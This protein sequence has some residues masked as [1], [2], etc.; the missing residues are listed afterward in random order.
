MLRWLMGWGMLGLLAGCATLPPAETRP[1][2][3][4]MASVERVRAE[5]NLAVFNTGLGFGEPEAFR[6][7][8]WRRRLGGRGGEQCCAGGRGR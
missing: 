2:L 6:R 4:A 8:A 1:S 7:A 5:T 3:A